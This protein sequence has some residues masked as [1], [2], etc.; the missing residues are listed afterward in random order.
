MVGL[1]VVGFH[2]PL[3]ITIPAL[4]AVFDGTEG[5]TVQGTAVY[6]CISKVVSL[7]GFLHIQTGTFRPLRQQVVAESIVQFQV[8]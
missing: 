1:Y 2:I 8:A 7:I 6:G 5:N 4:H 3:D